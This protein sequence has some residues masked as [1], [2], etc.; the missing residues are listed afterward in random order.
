MAI[1]RV[2]V[3]ILN[4]E[5]RKFISGKKREVFLILLFVLL[6]LL[7]NLLDPNIRHHPLILLIDIVILIF[8]VM[9]FSSLFSQFLVDPTT[10]T[11][12]QRLQIFFWYVTRRNGSFYRLEKGAL[13][14]RHSSIKNPKFITLHIDAN[15][16]AVVIL[17]DDLKAINSGFH[18]LYP[19]DAIFGYFSTEKQLIE[20]G[21]ISENPFASFNREFETQEI[22]SNRLKRRHETQA[23]TK[24]GIEIVPNIS[25]WLEI[26]PLTQMPPV[27][28]LSEALDFPHDISDIVKKHVLSSFSDIWRQ[29]I[30]RRKSDDIFSN[31]RDC[32]VLDEI[33]QSMINSTIKLELP[34]ELGIL[35]R[36]VQIRILDLNV[37]NLRIQN[38]TEDQMV[39]KWGKFWFAKIQKEDD[40]LSSRSAFLEEQ[41]R[42][43][44]QM[45]L[46]KN[47]STLF[48]KVDTPK[49]T[50][51]NIA[52]QLISSS[53]S[54]MPDKMDADG[55]QLVSDI[56]KLTKTSRSA[57]D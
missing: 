8:V 15:S 12:L 38:E 25:F 20:I 16:A 29:E 21:P 26:V 10:F 24:D 36:V 2:K 7:L 43:R 32:N 49:C 54:A 41:F 47:I 52:S 50:A 48:L 31:E 11:P 56:S 53:L 28:L 57:D 39:Q 22:F 44:A 18:I 37:Y 3:K 4:M 40:H 34:N 14:S 51:T 17:N 46:A 1:G 5:S 35:N 19:P 6:Y 33:E 42:R 23:F 30:S 9:G 13:D 45:E 55:R 27:K